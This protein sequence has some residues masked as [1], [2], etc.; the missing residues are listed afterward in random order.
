LVTE[1]KD[2]ME[3]IKDYETSDVDKLIYSEKLKEVALKV[4]QFPIKE[5]KEV[6]HVLKCFYVNN[7]DSEKQ[8][9][10]IKE[11]LN[12]I[13]WTGKILIYGDATGGARAS[14]TDKTN[15]SNIKYAFQDWEFYSEYGTSNPDRVDRINSVNNKLRNADN[16]IGMYVDSKNCKPL[17]NDFQQVT[18]NENGELDKGR[19][20][21]MGLNHTVEGLGYLVHKRLKQIEVRKPRSFLI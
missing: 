18:R 15:W 20:E 5:Q 9:S 3:K 4:S 21:R 17:I 7:T 6:L 1:K 14:A 2:L 8:S 12:S 16:E 13:A 11:W 10:L 19:L